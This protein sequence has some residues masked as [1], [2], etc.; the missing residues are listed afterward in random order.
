MRVVD[1]EI[2]FDHV[3]VEETR[4]NKPATISVLEWIDF[5]QNALDYNVD[6]VDMLADELERARSEIENLRATITG[7]EAQRV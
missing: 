6:E 2:N 3:M 1:I 5:W 7:L 4:V